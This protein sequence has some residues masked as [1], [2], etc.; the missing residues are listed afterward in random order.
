MDKSVLHSSTAAYC[1]SVADCFEEEEEGGLSRF[2]YSVASHTLLRKTSV[3]TPWKEVYSYS[4]RGRQTNDRA[5]LS[6]IIHAIS[7]SHLVEIFTD[8]MFSISILTQ[9]LDGSSLRD[10]INDTN[11]DLIQELIHATTGRTWTH[12]SIHHARSHQD[13]QLTSDMLLLFTQ[14]GN[15]EADRHAGMVWRQ[16]IGHTVQIF[17]EQHCWALQY[18]GSFSH[19]FFVFSLSTLQTLLWRWPWRTNFWSWQKATMHWHIE[20]VVS[21]RWYVVLW[22]QTR[23][24]DDGDTTTP[25]T[26]CPAC[27]GIL[28]CFDMATTT[29]VERS[30]YQLAGTLH[31]LCVDYC[32]PSPRYSNQYILV[33]PLG[34]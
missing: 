4:V 32:L 1:N 26:L 10:H 25:V 19:W 17:G 33:D 13:M 15:D 29:S 11:A 31:W 28:Q 21:V 23:N 27:S 6:A 8:S 20:R 2:G 22:C 3:E 7:Q 18:N 30:W 16:D 14:L 9:I 12:I 34:L 5:E 24:M